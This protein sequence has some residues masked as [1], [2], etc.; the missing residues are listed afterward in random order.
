MHTQI[1]SYLT[2]LL[3]VEHV[4]FRVALLIVAAHYRQPTHAIERIFHREKL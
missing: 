3:N 2:H 4:P 1:I